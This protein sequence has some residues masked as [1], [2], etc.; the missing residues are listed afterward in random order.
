MTIGNL[1]ACAPQWQISAQANDKTVCPPYLF[2]DNYELIRIAIE[3]KHKRTPK[4]QSSANRRSLFNNRLAS[5]SSRIQ[6]G[7]LN[8]HKDDSRFVAMTLQKKVLSGDLQKKPFGFPSLIHCCLCFWYSVF[9]RRSKVTK[10]RSKTGMKIRNRNNQLGILSW[11][12]FRAGK[13]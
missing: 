2:F 3:M 5:G 4:F 13:A 11:D 7:V 12:L 9:T 1:N 8:S 10:P 6:R